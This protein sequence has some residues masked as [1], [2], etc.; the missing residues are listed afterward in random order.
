MP[1]NFCQFLSF[2]PKTTVSWWLTA[3]CSISERDFVSQFSSLT[4]IVRIYFYF[5]PKT[6]ERLQILATYWKLCLVNLMANDG[7]YPWWS[8]NFAR[9]FSHGY[10]YLFYRKNFLITGFNDT[11]TVNLLYLNYAIHNWSH[12]LW[13]ILFSSTMSHYLWNTCV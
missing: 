10:L 5:N 4:L 13:P 2:L 1:I 6:I 8:F 11:R 9:Q 12:V 3:R 7:G